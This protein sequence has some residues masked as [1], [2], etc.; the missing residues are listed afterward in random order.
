MLMY[1]MRSQAEALISFFIA[2]G[3]GENELK[4]SKKNVRAKIR[5]K[6]SYPTVFFYIMYG[7]IYGEI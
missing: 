6:N 3:I 7:A 4:F 1:K 2:N 5:Q